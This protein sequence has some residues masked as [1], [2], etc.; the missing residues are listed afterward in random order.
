MQKTIFLAALLI[1]LTAIA[2]G[3]D[4]TVVLTNGDQYTGEIVSF[5]LGVF[6]VKTAYGELH[7]PKEKVAR[8]EFSRDPLK[9]FLPEVG[10]MRDLVEALRAAA[11]GQD[12]AQDRH[13]DR[14]LLDTALDLIEAYRL[15]EE[16][17]DRKEKIEALM[18]RLEGLA[19]RLRPEP[20]KEPEKKE[21]GDY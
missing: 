13:A 4:E 10:A 21:G 5:E 9:Q 16:V 11:R 6:H 2:A 17:K 19:P 20:E 18:R 1:G 7:I 8:I 14:D 15:P 3:Q 12:P